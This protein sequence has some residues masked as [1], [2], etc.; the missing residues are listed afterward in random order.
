MSVLPSDLIAYGSAY[1]PEADGTTVG[2]SVDFSRR[3]AFFDITPAGTINFVSSASADTGVQIQVAGRDSS[4]VIQ[5]PSAV[6]LNGTTPVSGS[7][8]FERLLYGVVSGANPASAGTYFPLAGPTGGTGTT[9]SGSMTNSATSMGVNSHTNFPSSGN[10]YIAVDTG[11]N[12]EIMEVTGGQGTTTWTVTRGV[13]GFQ[14]G[15]AHSSGVAVYL[16]PVGD[17]AAISN[18]A[19]ISGH[20]AQGGSANHSGTTPALMQLQ[21]GDGANVSAG[22]IIQIT[23][24]T[25]S[26]VEYQLRMIIATSG[27]GTDYVAINRD[28]STVPTSSTTYS[29][30]QGMLFETGFAS[31]GS[32]Y[33]D[34]NPVTSVVRCFSTAAAD[35]PTGSERYY[36]EKIFTVNNNTATALT[37][38]QVEVASETPTLPSGALLDAALTTAFNDTNTCNPRQQASSFVPTGSGSFVTQP[39]F[40]SVTANSGALSDG[41][42]PNFSGAQAVWLRLTLPAGTAAYKGAADLRTQG[43]TT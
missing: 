17:V 28:W 5:T 10:Y 23:N 26:G 7:Q 32:T 42:A 20:T 36:F 1:M 40:I 22:Q 24:N 15:V 6:T 41:A 34:P 39:A 2:G 16:M 38:A 29:V 13:S 18:T 25:P 9:T 4:G 31:S 35:V 33:G 43:T 30:F 3:V 19:V 11:T 37:S 8:T 12:F 21:S 14:G 27:Y